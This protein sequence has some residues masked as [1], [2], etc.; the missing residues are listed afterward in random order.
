[1]SILLEVLGSAGVGSVIGGVFGYLGKREERKNLE[2]KFGHD[3]DMLN[4]KT[5][6]QVKMKEMGIQ[7]AEV[8]GRLK[9]EDTEANAFAISQRS[10]GKFSDNL[11]SLVRPVILGILLYQSFTMF[12]SLDEIMGG[13]E[14]LPVGEL[15][16]LYKIYVLSITSLTGTAIGWYFAA[17][18]SKQFDQLLTR[19][20]P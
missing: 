11:K 6:A 14:G 8:S 19:W 12:T 17:R 3:F 5:D 13:L 7:A 4:A 16:G 20:N 9:V 10:T 2:M 1:M 15:A 18:S